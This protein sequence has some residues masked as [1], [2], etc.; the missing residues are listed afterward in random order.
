M[1]GYG[2]VQEAVIE[3]QDESSEPVERQINIYGCQCLMS[4]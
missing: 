4:Q 3:G 1:A 2:I